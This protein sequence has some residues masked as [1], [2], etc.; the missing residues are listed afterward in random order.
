M[1]R[2]IFGESF[3]NCF[4]LTPT[5]SFS[6]NVFLRIFSVS[7]EGTCLEIF[8]GRT[9]RRRYGAD[10]IGGNYD[11][12]NNTQKKGV[13]WYRYSLKIGKILEKYIWRSSSLLSK[14]ADWEPATLPKDEF[15][16]NGYFLRVLFKLKVKLS[17]NFKNLRTAVFKEHMYARVSGHKHYVIKT[18]EN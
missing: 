9:K 18:K 4:L 16:I 14:Q 17:L 12:G 2:Q 6:C 1:W 5:V 11:S 7:R 8:G 15:L 13:S 3:L 10:N